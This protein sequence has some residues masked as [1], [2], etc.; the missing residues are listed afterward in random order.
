MPSPFTSSLVDSTAHSPLVLLL[1]P[2]PVLPLA[3]IP[4]NA[5][6]SAYGYIDSLSYA[7]QALAT[8]ALG[9]AR[10]AGGFESAIQLL[11]IGL[12][13]GAVVANMA[14]HRVVEPPSP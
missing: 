6:L 11:V 7:G 2:T 13:T 10:E 8:L 4:A 5:P 1:Q 3:L 9:G 14:M 12:A